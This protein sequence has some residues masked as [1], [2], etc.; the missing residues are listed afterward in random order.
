VAR[1]GELRE[2]TGTYQWGPNTDLYLQIWT[3][4]SGTPQLVAFDSAVARFVS[5][6][7]GPR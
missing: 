3:E 1:T 4:L 7:F 2:F 6:R 5:L